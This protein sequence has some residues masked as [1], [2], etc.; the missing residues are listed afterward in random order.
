MQNIRR[1][2]L[3]ALGLLVL[4]FAALGTEIVRKL[5]I[6][7]ALAVIERGARTMDQAG[8]GE[9][10]LFGIFM[11]IGF[12]IAILGGLITASIP[13]LHELFG[14][15]ATKSIYANNATPG[16]SHTQPTYIPV[17]EPFYIL[18]P[19]YLDLTDAER[20]QINRRILDHL[21]RGRILAEGRPDKEYNWDRDEAGPAA[22]PRP[23]T[24]PQ[25]YWGGADLTYNFFAGSRRRELVHA[26]PDKDHKHWPTY[27]DVQFDL[28][29]VERA[30]SVRRLA[31]NNGLLN[32]LRD[33]AAKIQAAFQTLPDQRTTA[34]L[35]DLAKRI[36]AKLAGSGDLEAISASLWEFVFKY[37][38]IAKEVEYIQGRDYISERD[39]E[40]LSEY[41]ASHRRIQNSVLSET[42]S[43]IEEVGRIK[44]EYS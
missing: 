19:N 5:G 20:A 36:R 15:P 28:E 16:V 9:W 43:L 31:V 37:A 42:K 17:W 41:Q 10:F 38:A 30:L 26:I 35:Q 25:K 4:A 33:V 11:I 6:E 34:G 14:T 40:A 8:Y 18:A 23:T 1:I 44:Q 29:S 12:M 24:I 21:A 22:Q 7:S 39:E 3:A 27:R 13:W 2:L 32:E